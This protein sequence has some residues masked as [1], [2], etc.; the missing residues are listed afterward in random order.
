[1]KKHL[2]YVTL[3]SLLLVLIVAM[4]M[5]YIPLYGKDLGLS[6]S[7]IGF[8]IVIYHITQGIGRIPIGTLSDTIGYKIIISVGGLSAFFGSIAYLLSS[9]FWPLV[10]LAQILFGIAVSTTWVAIPAFIT[11]FGRKN[12]PMYAFSVGWAY[13][14]AIPIGGFIKEE[15]GMEPLFFIVFGLSVPLLI[16]LGLLW[17]NYPDEGK[18]NENKSSF[19]LISAYKRSFNSLK[20][21]QVLRACLYSFLMFMGFAIGFSLL[22]LYLLGVGLTS[23]LIGIVQFFRMSASSS[24]CLLT[25]RIGRK[26]GREKILTLGTIM[27]GLSL[28]LISIVDSLPLLIFISIIWGLSGGLYVPIVFYLIADATETKNRGTGMGVRGTMGTLGSSLGVLIFSCLAETLDIS[29][30]IFLAG[31]AIII[32]VLITEIILRGKKGERKS[33]HFSSRGA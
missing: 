1:M 20:N 17:I 29:I 10:F 22:P 13:A 27:V 7:T 11:Q 33:R 28:A 3:F 12:I 31:S 21:P 9:A 15:L 5:P 26:I 18:I 6:V 2:L 24:V 14:F 4:V 30:S 25:E 23:A 32:G 19:S 16:I 8:V